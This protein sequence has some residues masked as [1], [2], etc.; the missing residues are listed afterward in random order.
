MNVTSKS[1]DNAIAQNQH[2]S[3]TTPKSMPVFISEGAELNP[4]AMAEILQMQD[5]FEMFQDEDQQDLNDYD[6]M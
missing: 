5:N 6:D 3:S 4:E 2:K 1:L